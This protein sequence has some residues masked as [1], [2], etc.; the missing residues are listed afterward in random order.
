MVERSPQALGTWDSKLEFP[1]WLVLWPAQKEGAREGGGM[2]VSR[3][4]VREEESL[5]GIKVIISM[6]PGALT[7]QSVSWA[8]CFPCSFSPGP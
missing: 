6:T 5:D 1:S 2:P 8:S 4:W 7:Q 3:V